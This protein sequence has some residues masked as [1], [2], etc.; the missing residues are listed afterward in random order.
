METS[1]PIIFI[2]GISQSQ[3][4]NPENGRKVWFSPAGFLAHRD[5]LDVRHALAVKNNEIDQQTLAPL[6][7]EYGV[8]AQE[9]ILIERMCAYFPTRPVY[10]FSYD[11]RHSAAENADLLHKQIE[12]V[13]SCGGENV[14][15]VCHSMGGLVTSAFVKKYGIDRVHKIVALSVPFE[16]SAEILHIALTGN[17]LLVPSYV[18]EPMGLK[19]EILVNYPGLSDLMPTKEYLC[20]HPLQRGNVCMTPEEMESALQE[21]FLN[22]Y[23]DA[24]AFQDSIKTDGH[25]ILADLPNTY[26]GIGNGRKTMHSLSLNKDGVKL[27]TEESGDGIVPYDS[28]VMNGYITQLPPDAAGKQRIRRFF[29]SHSDILKFKEPLSWLMET[30]E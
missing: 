19:K 25:N 30:L 16:G 9:I 18:V 24:R 29:C 17:I 21:M 1:R 20:L 14:D 23:A 26:F 22:T 4:Y 7:R 10:F 12:Y 11:F 5:L 6:Q 13:L 2:P 28:L 8:M 27:I 15:L 3:L